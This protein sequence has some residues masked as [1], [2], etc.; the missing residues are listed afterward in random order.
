VFNL[1]V[2]QSG[3]H[4]MLQHDVEGGGTYED[5]VDSYGDQLGVEGRTI[6]GILIGARDRKKASS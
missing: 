1:E 6:L 5:I 3:F 2:R 4:A